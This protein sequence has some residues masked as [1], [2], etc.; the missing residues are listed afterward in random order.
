MKG[1]RT[2]RWLGGVALAALWG[3]GCGGTVC[4]RAEEAS[5][6]LETR[7]Q[8]CKTPGDFEGV[9]SAVCEQGIDSCSDAERDAMGAYFACV[10][11]LPPCT[12]ETREGFREAL[13]ACVQPLVDRGMSE[14]CAAALLP[15]DMEV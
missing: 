2:L 10:E 8:A 15:S 9:T 6:T 7:V 14:A 12:L 11:S 13:G 3:V 5:R 1:M 4:E